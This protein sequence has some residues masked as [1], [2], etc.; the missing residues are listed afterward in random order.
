MDLITVIVPVYMAEKYLD[1]CIFSI[2]H[3]TY[4]NIE[5]ILVD[6]G[7]TD[8]SP[9]ICECWAK[10]DSRVRVCLLYTSPSPRD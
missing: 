1:R 2:C 5:L 8:Q 4:K 10:K 3:Q 7:S 6:D 9:Y